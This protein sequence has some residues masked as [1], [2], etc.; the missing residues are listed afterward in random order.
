MKSVYAYPY[1][2]LVFL[3]DEQKKSIDFQLDAYYS[4]IAYNQDFKA[5][6]VM[7][8]EMEADL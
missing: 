5:P 8:P 2:G 4:Q 6:E 3:D 1:T 7:A